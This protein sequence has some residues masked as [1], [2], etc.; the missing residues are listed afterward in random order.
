MI[1]KN[2]GI[3]PPQR[4][5]ETIKG[6]TAGQNCPP[7]RFETSPVKNL[8]ANQL[9]SA[10]EEAVFAELLPFLESV[11]IACNE[12]LYQE[13]DVIDYAYFP[14]TAV[15]SEFQILEDGR[16]V[17]IAMTGREGVVGLLPIF[18]SLRAPHWTQVSV[19]GNLFRISSRVLKNKLFHHHSLQNLLFNYLNNY[20]G[21]ISQRAVCNSY[22]LIEQ[23]FCCWLL[24]LHNRKNSNKLPL[25]QEQIARFLGVHRPSITNIAQT[26]R[27]KK[28]I[29]YVRGNIYILNRSEL[30]KYACACYSEIDK[31]LVKF[32]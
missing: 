22:H 23:R 9:L 16:T 25:T 31:T 26:L 1:I 17:E 27:S 32:Y 19:G 14:E 6:W 7:K 2:N 3:K 24:M 30:E 18:N 10:Q 29:D 20:V 5:A 12:Y 13:G 11:N 8:L 28:I 21:Q 4:I 15:I